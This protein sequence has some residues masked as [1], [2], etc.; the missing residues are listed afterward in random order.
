MW[1][2]CCIKESRFV[3]TGSIFEQPR[4]FRVQEHQRWRGIGGEIGRWPFYGLLCL[5]V[6]E[7]PAGQKRQR[8]LK[9]QMIGAGTVAV[10]L[11]RMTL[12]T[13]QLAQFTP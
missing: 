2:Y 9:C 8:L 6:S 13:K 10:S 3:F 1:C 5:Q 4:S 12:M 11:L 7:S